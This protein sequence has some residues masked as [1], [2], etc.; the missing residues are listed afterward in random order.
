[1]QC[2][3]LVI[4][5]LPNIVKSNFLISK[6]KMWQFPA[7]K[8]K[9]TVF[10]AIGDLPSLESGQDSGIK[11]HVAKNHNQQHILW[12]Q[13]TPTGK[14][15]LDNEVFFRRK[16]TEKSKALPQLINAL[17]GTSQHQP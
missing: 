2:L 9:I 6:H 4:M 7:K 15:A 11:Y 14:T 12:M 5:I 17:N 8:P 10:D 16:I 1:M 3:M 13:H